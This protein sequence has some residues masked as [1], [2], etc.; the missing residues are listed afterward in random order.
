MG[1]NYNKAAARQAAAAAGTKVGEVLG[2]IGVASAK[3]VSAADTAAQAAK[4]DAAAQL[5]EQL[6]GEQKLEKEM[7]EGMTAEETN[8]D[9]E[10][11]K[12]IEST[13]DSADDNEELAVQNLI[14]LYNQKKKYFDENPTMKKKLLDKVAGISKEAFDSDFSGGYGL[15][16]SNPAF[17]EFLV[18]NGYSESDWNNATEIDY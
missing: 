4:S 16:D 11:N 10:I 2:G 8:V 5:Y 17:Y 14:D 7:T 15:Q 9:N 18:N 1:A 13:K 12:A 6:T 3:D